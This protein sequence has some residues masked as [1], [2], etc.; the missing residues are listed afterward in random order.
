MGRQIRIEPLEGPSGPRIYDLGVGTMRDFEIVNVIIAERR[1]QST[2]G[3]VDERSAEE[4]GLVIGGPIGNY[5]RKTG[6]FEYEV[7]VDG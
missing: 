6:G 4:I 2:R 5:L 1:A 7:L 3:H